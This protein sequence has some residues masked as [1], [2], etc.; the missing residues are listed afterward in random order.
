MYHVAGYF[1]VRPERRVEGRPTRLGTGRLAR[2]D[3][4]AT[5]PAHGR[6]VPGPIRIRRRA[7][8]GRWPM[9]RPDEKLA[10]LSPELENVGRRGRAN[11]RH[12]LVLLR[13]RLWPQRSLTAATLTRDT[14]E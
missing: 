9:D 5:S 3:P 7:L 10:R 2:G 6:V 1:E 8:L 11:V 12:G 13:M 4:G 14:C